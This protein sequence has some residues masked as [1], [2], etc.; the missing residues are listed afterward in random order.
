MEK[1]TYEEVRRLLN[2]DELTGIFTNR[3]TRNNQ[4][5]KGKIAGS[6]GTDGY[7]H[8]QINEKQGRNGGCKYEIKTISRF[9]LDILT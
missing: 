8:M 7:W 3:T 1:I 4:A 6:L 9:T 2:Y 5:L